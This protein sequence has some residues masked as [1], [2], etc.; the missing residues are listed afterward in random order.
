MANK[1]GVSEQVIS[2]P[3]GGGALKGIGETFQPNLFSGTGNHSIPIAISPGRNGFGPTL[4]LQYSSGNGNG[5]FGLGWQLSIPRITRK[6]EKGLPQ[7]ADTDVFVMSGAEDLVPCLTKVV[8]P[9]GGQ[10]TWLPEDPTNRPLHTVY[11]YRPR[12]E[13]LFARIER[14]ENNAT[15]EVHWRAITRDNITSIY[16]AT[17]ASRV[18]DPE[19]E[20]RVYEWLLQETFDA[21]GNHILYEYAKDNPQL[22]TNED[23]S[24]RLNAIFEQNR[25]ATQL[26]IRRIYYGNFP[27]P[28]LDEN[29][30]A[31]K[32]PNGTDIGHQRGG[33]R[34]AFEVVFDYG[35]WEI[36]TKNSHPGPVPAGQQELFGPDP[37]N[38]SE[39]NPVPIR[40]DRFSS[41]RAGFEIR[42]LRRCRRVLMFHH[43]AELGSPTLVRSTDFEYRN[44]PD[45]RLSL[46]SAATVTSYQKD[47]AGDYISAN[48]PPVTFKYSEFR[49]HEQRYQSIVAQGNDMPPL[50]LNDPSVALVDLFGDGLP[51]VLQSSLAG[52]RYWR[53][54]GDGFLDRPRS[55]PQIPAGI[56]LAQPGVGFGDMG[57]D[58]RADLLVHSGPLPGFFETTSEGTWQTFKPYE[59]FP[60]FD[61]AD[62]NVR[63]VDL[64][65]DG[66]SDAL[67]T[68]DQHFYGS[69]VWA[70]KGSHRLNT[71]RARTTSTNSRMSISTIP[72]EESASPT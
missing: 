59:S 49:P 58:G 72:R 41:F 19:N 2:L 65:G 5:P 40:E 63:L 42:T 57:G 52:F 27:D 26:Y 68:R 12:T 30:N 44:D 29:G 21:T 38:S 36:P 25:N 24:L 43:F 60:S 47:A 46:L 14:W 53:N 10:E 56:A 9:T 64:T 67:M 32:Y 18:A 23:P 8:D 7:Y 16:G 15:N 17:S 20:Q 39:Q 28:L 45:T 13:G 66:S 48:M 3:K 1:S 33:R 54:L 51:D 11:R 55:M 50:A 37:S 34:Y 4:S 62:P 71:S 6:T 31:V 35:D 69:N 22:Y 61:L 70:K